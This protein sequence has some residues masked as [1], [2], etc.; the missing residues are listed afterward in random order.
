MTKVADATALSFNPTL[1]AA[2]CMVT[3]AVIV[4]GE[5]YRVEAFVGFVPSV[6]CWIEAPAVE[7]VRVTFTDPEKLA[8]VRVI[9]GVATLPSGPESNSYLRMS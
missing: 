8:T 6:V 1:N 7:V 9:T 3:L 5:V 4:S 2:A